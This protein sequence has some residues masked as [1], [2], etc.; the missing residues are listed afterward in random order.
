M[1][2]AE[3]TGATD[4]S[5]AAGDAGWVPSAATDLDA[6]MAELHRQASTLAP[7]S[8]AATVAKH[9]AEAVLEHRCRVVEAAAGDAACDGGEA[10]GRRPAMTSSGPVPLLW[11]A[12]EQ[13]NDAA[14]TCLCGLDS[15]AAAALEESDGH[16]VTPLYVAAQNGHVAVCRA[17]LSAGALVDARRDTGATPLFIAAQNNHLGAVSL[18]LEGGADTAA[19]NSQDCTPFVLACSMGHTEVSL[20]LLRWGSSVFESAGGRRAMAWARTGGHQATRAAVELFLADELLQRTAF[21]MW[22]RWVDRRSGAGTPPPGE[23]QAAVETP[24]SGGPRFTPPPGLP[25]RLFVSEIVVPTVVSTPPPRRF[26]LGQSQPVATGTLR[27]AP[28]RGPKQGEPEGGEGECNGQPGP[29][30]PAVSP[31]PAAAPSFVAASSGRTPPRQ[32]SHS[33]RALVH[34]ESLA[35]ASPA[36]RQE[37]FHELML[38]GGIAAS[39]AELRSRSRVAHTNA[40]AN[41]AAAGEAA[42]RHSALDVTSCSSPSLPA[43][44]TTPGSAST[45]RPRRLD[46]E[47]YGSAASHSYP[48][49]TAADCEP[50]PVYHRTNAQA[51]ALAR[52]FDA[53]SRARGAAQTTVAGRG[54]NGGIDYG[55]VAK[56][57]RTLTSSRTM[58]AQR[59]RELE[60]LRHARPF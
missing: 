4:T 50:Q 1:S 53:S 16:S 49:S 55:A 29:S 42:G 56:D 5:R 8:I 43:G 14:V 52:R 2:S 22:R 23:A 57:M 6:D 7:A 11:R 27:S 24:P 51:A 46:G 60:A 10:V 13:G 32:P 39:P 31:R 25:S 19:R 38:V 35:G 41:A 15:F 59:R 3:S 36:V 47:S 28:R 17:L 26:A 12:A 20:L 45:V 48:Q 37:V 33:Y 58:D 9:G 18:L 21:R 34:S 30:V 40:M 44:A 54:G